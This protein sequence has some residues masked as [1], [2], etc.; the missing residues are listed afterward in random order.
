MLEMNKVML[1]GNLTRDPDLSYLANGT[2][3]AKLG[4]AVNRS[5]RDKGGQWQKEAAFVDIDAWGA[6]A[7][8]C[9][10]HLQKGRRVYVE[11][12]LKFDQWEAQDGSRRSKLGVVAERVQFADSRPKGESGGESDGPPPASTGVPSAAPAAP[13]PPVSA[14]AP[15][16]S[17]APPAGGADP[18]D[19]LP[20]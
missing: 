19:D 11:G 3:L 14:P 17:T 9:S 12:R 15:G 16:A 1:I 2:A 18:A 13:G 4:L 5:Y 10:K 7:E 20:F 6:Q 8:F